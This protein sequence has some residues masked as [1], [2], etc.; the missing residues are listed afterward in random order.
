MYTTAEFDIQQVRADFPILSTKVYGK[1][2][3]YYDNGATTQKP[4]VVIR[5]LEEYYKSYNSNVHRGVHY[6]SQKA[7]D[8]QEEARRTIAR[9]INARSDREIIFTRGTTESINLVAYSFGKR[10]VK[11]GDEIII[12]AMEHHSNLVPW[13]QLCEDRGAVLRV[14]PIYAN[15]E[16]VWE[17]CEELL[18][19][20]T[21]LVAVTWVSNALGTVNPVRRIIEA[22]HSRNIP[23]LLDAAQAIQ[24]IPVDVQ[25]LDADFLVFSGH[26]IYGPTGIGV[27]YGKEELLRELP[28]YQTGGSMIKQV[29]FDK[30]TWADLP[31][32]F[33][34]G[35]PDVAGII[36]LGA[37]IEYVDHLGIGQ[38]A[39][40]EHRLMQYAE[41]QLSSI[42]GIKL[43]GMPEERTGAL[44]FLADGIHPFDLGELLDKQGIAVR[45]GHHCCQPVMDFYDI[46]GTVRASFAFYNTTEEVDRLVH[47]VKKGIAMLG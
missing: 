4:E 19:N 35:T 8:A 9:F 36:G 12:S 21:R 7:T 43:I 46:P 42:P 27:L 10:Y 22:A 37:A 29:T 5:S 28:P 30:T 6:L 20:K 44:S 18:N 1:P 23:V 47:G 13:Q 33:E 26:K 2:N 16:L 3:V 31:F 39:E 41:Q 40:A 34:A 14:I 17:A 32:K 24:H 11:A 15:G 25:E 38:I 45:T